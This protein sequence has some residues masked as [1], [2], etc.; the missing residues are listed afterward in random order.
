MYRYIKIN[1]LKEF[2]MITNY[3]KSKKYKT[4]PDYYNF[5]VHIDDSKYYIYIKFDPIEKI[6]DWFYFGKVNN[7]K[8]IDFKYFMREEKL[9]RINNN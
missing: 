7:I 1:S 2:K 5:E 4:T 8:P 9:K 6:L 3:F